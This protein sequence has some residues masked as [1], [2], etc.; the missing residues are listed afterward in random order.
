MR[1]IIQ[2]YGKRVVFIVADFKN[3]QT[4]LL[5]SKYKVRSVPHYVMIDSRGASA[6][7]VGGLSK[8]EMRLFIEAGLK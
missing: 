6:V 3:E 8:E 5:A 1:E 7:S 2:E 4:H